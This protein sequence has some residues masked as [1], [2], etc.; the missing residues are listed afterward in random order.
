MVKGNLAKAEPKLKSKGQTKTRGN[1]GKPP[2]PT[3]IVP[4]KTRK[5]KTKKKEKMLTTFR[6]KAK[7]KKSRK[8]KLKPTCRL[9]ITLNARCIN[10]FLLSGRQRHHVVRPLRPLLLFLGYL[11]LPLPFC[12]SS[13]LF[14]S[15][16]LLSPLFIVFFFFFFFLLSFLVHCLLP[17]NKDDHH[18]KNGIGKPPSF[19]LL[20][21]ASL[22]LPAA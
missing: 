5:H 14:S 10:S 3:H 2:H 9:K 22:C 20:S 11:S 17:L 15:F 16:P 18:K 19:T 12:L 4:Y 13:P 6:K 1:A 7:K 21:L 8:L